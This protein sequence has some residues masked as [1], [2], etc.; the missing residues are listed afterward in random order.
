M[1]ARWR[2]K[3]VEPDQPDTRVDVIVTDNDASPE[4]R[5]VLVGEPPVL[6]AA[7]GHVNDALPVRPLRARHVL[8]ITGP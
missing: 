7:C 3:E 6:D 4:R 1:F 8:S 2:P 5:A